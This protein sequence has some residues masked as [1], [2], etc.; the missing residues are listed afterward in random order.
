MYFNEVYLDKDQ[1]FILKFGKKDELKK[2]FFSA[3]TDY[4]ITSM[5]TLIIKLHN[6]D[7]IKEW[8]N[9]KKIKNLHCAKSVQIRS[10]FRNNYVFGHFSCSAI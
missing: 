9:D 4:C 10:Y 7:K 3:K 5:K 6:D 8:Q 1:K 2:L